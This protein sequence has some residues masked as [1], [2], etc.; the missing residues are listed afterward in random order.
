MHQVINWENAMKKYDVI[1]VGAGPAGATAA[2]FLAKGG[3]SALLLEKELIPRVKPCAGG[4]PHHIDSLLDED[5]RQDLSRRVVSRICDRTLFTFKFKRAV[6]LASPSVSYRMVMRDM[7]DQFLTEWAVRAGAE[8]KDGLTVESV[9]QESDRVVVKTPGESFSA[10]YVIGADGPYSRVAS[11]TGLVA[12]RVF[13]WAVNAEVR[14]PQE[15]LEKQGSCVAID[16]GTVP[17]GY[18]WIF[19]KA[20]HL[21]CGLGTGHSRLPGMKELMH[22]CL[23]GFASTRR[24]LEVELRGYPLCAGQSSTLRINTDRVFLAGDAACLTDPLTGEGIY[25]SMLSGKMAALHLK[26]MLESLTG[27]SD[28]LRAD[29]YSEAIDREIRSELV[30]ADKFYGLVRDYPRIVYELGVANPLVRERFHQIFTGSVSYAALYK[31]LRDKYGSAF[32]KLKAVLPV[33]K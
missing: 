3:I 29:Q 5:M 18:A 11:T 21:S 28:S 23:K 24:A 9:V 7:F 32:R 16:F 10:S 13:G 22:R 12:S 6:E 2:R 8:L 15:D 1:I 25:Y 20:E 14:V 31:E 17:A 19:P 33:R 27:G 4:L 26:N 30:Y